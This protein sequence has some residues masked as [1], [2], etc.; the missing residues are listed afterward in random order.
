MGGGGGSYSDSYDRD[1][2]KGK[3]NYRRKKSVSRFFQE[4]KEVQ[5]LAVIK[6]THFHDDN[7][8][9]HKEWMEKL[10]ANGMKSL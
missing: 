8:N 4:V 9:F 5:R 6:R 2:Y 10:L 7:F 1:V 3:G